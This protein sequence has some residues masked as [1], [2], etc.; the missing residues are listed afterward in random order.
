MVI[1]KEA[2]MDKR[3]IDI[4]TCNDYPVTGVGSSDPKRTAPKLIDL[5]EYTKVFVKELRDSLVNR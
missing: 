1:P 3:F 2:N 5:R 4:G